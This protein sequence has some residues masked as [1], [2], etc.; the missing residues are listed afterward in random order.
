MDV[1]VSLSSGSCVATRPR[2]DASE[3]LSRAALCPVLWT[4]SA[5]GEKIGCAYRRGSGAGFVVEVFRRIATVPS[6]TVSAAIPAAPT[7]AQG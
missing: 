2:Y 7:Q 5:P 4:Q 3:R 1:T 6:R